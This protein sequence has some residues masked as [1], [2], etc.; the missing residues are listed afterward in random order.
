MEPGWAVRNRG[1][2][3]SQGAFM[4]W[5]REAE[6]A[7]CLCKIYKNN[8]HREWHVECERSDVRGVLG[9]MCSI[10]TWVAYPTRGTH[11]S[12]RVRAQWS[13]CRYHKSPWGF[14]DTKFHDGTQARESTHATIT[15][16]QHHECCVATHYNKSMIIKKKNLLMTLYDDKYDVMMNM[17]ENLIT[18]WW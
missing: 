3:G 13:A 10:L 11:E 6:L 15:I 8:Q 16:S 1:A 17:S 4:T 5:S 18:T 2:E 12:R 9:H 14:F 7:R